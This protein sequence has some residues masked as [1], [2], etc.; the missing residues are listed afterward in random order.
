MAVMRLFGHTDHSLPLERWPMFPTHTG[1]FS[2]LKSCS[3]YYE[4]KT[5]F[6]V[7]ANAYSDISLDDQPDLMLY[8]EQF[9]DSEPRESGKIMIC[10]H[11][12]QRGGVPRNIGHAV[13]I[14][15]WA[16]GGGWLT[17][18]DV[19]S[20]QSILAGEPTMTDLQAAI[21]SSS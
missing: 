1:D 15:T 18:L 11:T 9:N 7:H 3:A 4:T 19:N 13:C 12:P 17:C 20:G 5:H 10:G 16:H 21:A 8:W 2:S 6:F 14:D